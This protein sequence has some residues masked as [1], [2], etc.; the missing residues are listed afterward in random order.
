MEKRVIL[1]CLAVWVVLLFAADAFAAKS[2]FSLWRQCQRDEDEN[3]P[4]RGWCKPELANTTRVMADNEKFGNFTKQ[5][6]AALAPKYHAPAETLGWS[7]W[8]MGLEFSIN[9]IPGGNQWSDAF[10]GVE[11]FDNLDLTNQKSDSAPGLLHTINMHVRKGLPFST[12]LGFNVAYIL[13]SKM[14]VMGVEGKFAFVEGFT[15]AP[16]FAVRMN[17]S[18]LF[19]AADLDLDIFGWDLSVSKN[20]GIGGFL[21]LAPYTGYS[22]VYSVA[23]PHVINATFDSNNNDRLLMLDKQN[24]IIH[25]WFIGLRVIMTYITVTPEVII[26][27]AKVYNYSFSLGADF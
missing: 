9:D 14:F 19:N 16:D 1:S 26:S 21:Q 18:H 11:R 25:R 5:L 24:H 6:S 22:L 8:N 2:D 23:S 27:S 4:T 3:S 17:Y 20:F 15:Y 13:N 12:E 7:G 10:E